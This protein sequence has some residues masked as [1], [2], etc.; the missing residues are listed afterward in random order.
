MIKLFAFLYK[1]SRG[2]K[3]SRASI[4]FVVVVGLMAGLSNAGLLALINAT[5]NGAGLEPKKLIWAF[6][7]LCLLMFG[8]RVASGVVLNALSQASMFELSLQLSRRILAAP[9]RQLES[10]GAARLLATLTQDVPVIANT[11]TALPVLCMHIA[12][13]I[14]CFIYLG[15]LSWPMLAA[16]SVLVVLGIVTYQ[17]PMLSAVRYLKLAR[18]RKD[19]LLKNYRAVTEGTKELKLNRRRH[20]RFF[21]RYLQPSADAVRLYQL[22]GNNIFTIA[23][24]WGHML[25]FV[26]IGLLFFALPSW[27]TVSK[28]AMIG[29]TIILLYM[30]TPL[31]VILSAFPMLGQA[32]VAVQKIEKLGLSLE[33][34]AIE[35]EASIDGADLEFQS[36]EMREVCHSYYSERDGTSFTLG[37]LDLR[38]KPGELV[39][40]IGGNGSGKTT[41]IK[42]LMGL[43]FPEAGEIRLNGQTVDDETRDHY[44]Q[45]FAAVFSDFYLFESLLSAEHL[46]LD[47]AARAYLIQL[48]LDHKVQIDGG[49]FST[50]DLSQGQRKRLALL[51]AYLDDRPVYIFDEWAADQE[52][53]FKSVFYEELLPRLKARG[54]LVIVITHDDKYYDVADRL[55]KLD[56][57]KIEFDQLMNT[58]S[59]SV[60]MPNFV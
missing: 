51:T 58:R 52:P 12:V 55:I 22:R 18:D 30:M 5:V 54:K 33:P 2:I 23:A 49:A 26:V 47:E 32:N 27:L 17:L 59:S 24:G 50:L 7:G 31:E 25:I 39:F 48:Q 13:L 10:L 11:L 36:L 44:R 35:S 43:Y 1:C 4:I 46:E 34:H 45:S 41:F 37:P 20:Q 19:D 29:Y 21:D 8:C 38:F 6:A 57:G 15:W 42:L 14:G 16:V 9:L 40:V 53:M 28:E 3:R 60:S 56:Y